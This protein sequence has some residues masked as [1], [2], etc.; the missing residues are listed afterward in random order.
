MTAV[1]PQAPAAPPVPL[2]QVERM[3]AAMAKSGLFGIKTPDQALAL[4]LV[5]QAEGLH[6]AT[7][8]RDWHIISGKPA[9]KADAMLARF[10]AAGGRVEWLEMT[11]THCEAKFSHPAGGT[12]TIEWTPARAKLAGI[13]NDMHRKYPRQ[14]LRARCI[15]EGIRSVFPGCVAGAYTPEEVADMAP[16]RDS[17]PATPLSSAG[18]APAAPSDE[19]LQAARDAA[20]AGIAAYRAFWSQRNAAERRALADEHNALKAAAA[21]AD[22]KA[23]ATDVEVVQ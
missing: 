1:V 19:L 5:A 7:A 9:L 4:M 23:S 14:M 13:T 21:Q 8:A 3:A 6:P 20:M 2:D 22:A 17:L 11:D 16:A 15:S 18:T 10:Q 12:V